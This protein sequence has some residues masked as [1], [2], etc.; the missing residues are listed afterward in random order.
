ME[1]GQQQLRAY[2]SVTKVEATLKVIDNSVELCVTIILS[3][4]GRDSGYTDEI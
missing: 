1:I 3:H 2:L 4:S